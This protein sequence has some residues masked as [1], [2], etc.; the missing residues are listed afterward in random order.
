MYHGRNYGINQ[1]L[2]LLLTTW[3]QRV[4]YSSPSPRRAM[5]QP[6]AAM[7]AEG[8]DFSA[9][10][11]SE[12]TVVTTLHA[13]QAQRDILPS[14]SNMDTTSAVATAFL[15]NL[16]GGAACYDVDLRLVAEAAL[17]DEVTEA[18]ATIRRQMAFADAADWSVAS[19]TETSATVVAFATD[20]SGAISSTERQE[21]TLHIDLAASR[22]ITKVDV[23]GRS[24]FP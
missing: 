17:T 6:R 14:A 16:S 22:P 15:T 7:L 8:D 2:T 24:R 10:A 5:S 4:A 19:V 12:N 23:H 21:F 13:P 3:L 11:D 1:K 9:S 18:F 20:G